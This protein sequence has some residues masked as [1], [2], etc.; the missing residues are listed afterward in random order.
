MKALPRDGDTR[1]T[2]PTSSQMDGAKDAVQA[3]VTG[4]ERG[5]FFLALEPQLDLTTSEVVGFEGL[6]RW[7]HPQLG[8]CAPASFLGL[9]EAAGQSKALTLSLFRRLLLVRRQLRAHGF[10]GSLSL[11]ISQGVF[12]DPQLADGFLEIAHACQEVIAGIVLEVTEADAML[13]VPAAARTA[14]ALVKAGF[15][16]SIDD[17]WTGYSS[18]DKAQLGNFNEVKMDR[19]LVRL[20]DE[21]KIALAG[22]ASILAF[23]SNLGWRCVAEGIEDEAVLEKLTALGVRIGQGYL[24]SR[25][26]AEDAVVDWWRDHARRRQPPSPPIRRPAQLEASELAD[27]SQRAYPVW[28]FDLDKQAMV[29]ANTTALHFWRAESREELYSRSFRDMTPAA[30]NRLKAYRTRLVVTERI[31]ERW[32]LYPAGEPRPAYCVM[33]A[34][35]AEDGNLLMVV[36]AHEGFDDMDSGGMGAAYARNTSALCLMTTE[37]GAIT[38]R[39]TAAEVQLG[40]QRAH[41]RDLISEPHLAD[42]LMTEVSTQREINMNLRCKTLTGLKDY[43]A[44]ARMVPCVHSG[45]PSM[46]LTMVGNG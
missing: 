2:Y 4:I 5:E 22:A 1:D 30:L 42:S 44:G 19:S 16:L 28:I 33:Q 29:W 26:I 15:E 12:E 23:A 13:D 18:M 6:A 20:L 39:N 8:E 45:H 7:A 36:E 35:S 37:T 38:W 11:N 3:V 10:E 34:R 31:A 40:F 27:W 9:L 46:L 21:D 24:Y 14:R 25:P 43:R 32:V 41:L 17:F